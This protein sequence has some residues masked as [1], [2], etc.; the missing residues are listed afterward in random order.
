MFGEG[1]LS[2]LN[3]RDGNSRI[4]TDF[5][6]PFPTQARICAADGVSALRQDLGE[7]PA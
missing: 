6:N 1:V 3:I 2:L 4:A 7:C 5:S